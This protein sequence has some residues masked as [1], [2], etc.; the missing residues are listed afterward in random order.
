LKEELELEWVVPAKPVRY[1][2]G[3]LH[4]PALHRADG[5]G[6]EHVALLLKDGLFLGPGTRR[7][8]L[9]DQRLFGHTRF[10]AGDLLDVRAIERVGLAQDAAEN[11]D[12]ALGGG[13]ESVEFVM[14]RFRR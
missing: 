9:N 3:L 11:H 14:L 13:C 1:L 6:L 2:K 12:L 8:N 5:G 10:H 4:A 7:F